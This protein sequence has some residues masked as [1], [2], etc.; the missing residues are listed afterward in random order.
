MERAPWSVLELG[1][2]CIRNWPSS[3]GVVLQRHF[4][5]LVLILS[6]GSIACDDAQRSIV[7]PTMDIIELVVADDPI[8]AIGGPDGSG[9]WFE[10]I[11]D[12][13]R[14]SDG[15]FVVADCG[16]ATLHWFDP[17]GTQIVSRGRRGDGPG[18]FR[19]IHR[20]F[21]AGMDSLAVADALKM[22]ISVYDGGGR[23]DRVIPPLPLSLGPAPFGRLDDGTFVVRRRT[24]H[25]TRDDSRESYGL[26]LVS[27]RGL[28]VDSVVGLAGTDRQDPAPGAAPYAG[29]RLMLG[30]RAVFAVGDDKIYYGGQDGRGII[31]LNRSLSP[32][33]S[34]PT[35]TR[36]IQIDERVIA[37]FEELVANREHGAPD[38]LMPIA[39][40]QYADSL[41]AYG[42]LIAGADGGLWV[43]DPF[44]PPI[45]PRIWTKY[46]RGQPVARVEI[47]LRFF[48]LEFGDG[49]V[50]GVQFDE[51]TVESVQVL[52]TVEGRHSDRVVTPREGQ[53]PELPRCGVWAAR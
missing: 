32:I 2:M 52:K 42:D 20:V 47:P 43:Q 22:T 23:L 1:Q 16:L 11:V 19:L 49:W 12:A 45:Y 13:T 33:D 48:P 25:A 3:I 17:S 46:D 14:L 29:S 35:L 27:E 28:F 50:L 10:R 51:N 30:R 38:G 44:D 40:D 21:S 15:S 37:A 24:R 5:R 6:V 26:F 9:V 7:D 34:F 4:H 39:S 36:P 53:P 8:V 41:P 18:E 31:I